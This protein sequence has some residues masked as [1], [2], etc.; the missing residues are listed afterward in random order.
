ML[1][2]VIFGAVVAALSHGTVHM[3]E[4]KNEYKF[5]PNACVT[6]KVLDNLSNVGK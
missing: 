2:A 4:C 3:D 6:S 5:K 1:I